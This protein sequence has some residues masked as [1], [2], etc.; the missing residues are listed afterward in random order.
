[1]CGDVKLSSL[2]TL[3]DVLHAPQFKFNLLSVSA[4]TLSS[5]LIVH[6]LPDCFTIQDLRS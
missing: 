5:Q 6:F 1:M 3:K 2:L 4:L